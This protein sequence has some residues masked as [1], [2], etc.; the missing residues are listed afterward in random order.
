MR[1]AGGERSLAPARF[2]GRQLQHAARAF[3]AELGTTETT[4]PAPAAGAGS[5]LRIEQS[6]A[7]LDRILAS[8]MRQLI[9]E[10][11]WMTNA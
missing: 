1:S 10:R 3:R 11:L 7:K 6:Q 5:G 8:G 2:L 4:A 9:D